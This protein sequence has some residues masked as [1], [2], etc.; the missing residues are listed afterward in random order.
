MRIDTRSKYRQDLKVWIESLIKSLI[1]HCLF[2]FYNFSDSLHFISN[3]CLAL[4][5]AQ[6]YLGVLNDSRGGEIL[7]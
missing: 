5:D 4:E 3:V 1:K 6:G 2:I 7:A